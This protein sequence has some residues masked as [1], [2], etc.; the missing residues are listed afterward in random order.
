MN[1]Q[2]KQ[3]FILVIIL[4]VLGL[5]YAGIRFYNTKQEKK[6][7]AQEDAETYHV[8]QLKS[9]DITQ[10]SYI[11]NGTTLSFTQKGDDWNFDGDATV[12]IDESAV[13]TMLDAAASITAKEEIANCTD[14]SQY[15]LKEPS[16]VITLQ[17][18]SGIT[19]LYVGDKNAIT[20]QYYVKTGDSD[21]VYLMDSSVVT[22]FTKTVDEL[23][24]KKADD[25]ETVQSTE[26]VQTTETIQSTEA[27]QEP[28]TVDS[29]E[30]SIKK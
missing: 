1:K 17:T 14:L 19:T 30:S 26:A 21:T 15:G 20:S 2:K 10:F 8:T 6:K 22:D 4:V 3:F 16:N 12:D 7:S 11:L 27:V 25:T 5:V 9:S 28:Q 18:E 13:A 23:T 24:A 29:T